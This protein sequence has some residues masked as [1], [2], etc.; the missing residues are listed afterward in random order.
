L[1]SGIECARSPQR[2]PYQSVPPA[3]N[4]SNSHGYFDRIGHGVIPE[5]RY[6]R[7]RIAAVDSIERLA[8]NRDVQWRGRAG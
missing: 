8:R 5:K 3:G 2:S 4:F 7:P 1:G 6:V